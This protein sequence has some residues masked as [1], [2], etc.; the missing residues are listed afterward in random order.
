LRGG[1]ESC[2]GGEGGEIHHNTEQIGRE[3]PASTYAISE[4]RPP[5]V[6]VVFVMWCM[7]EYDVRVHAQHKHIP[8]N[9]RIGKEVTHFL[10]MDDETMNPLLYGKGSSRN[11]VHI[12]KLVNALKPSHTQITNGWKHFDRPKLD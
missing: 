3:N 7:H 1:Q 8:P 6:L 11:H 2:Q 5:A 10:P 9:S 4:T 12:H